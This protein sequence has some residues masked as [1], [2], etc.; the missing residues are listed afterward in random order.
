MNHRKRPRVG[1][2]RFYDAAR[3]V[4]GT[5]IVTIAVVGAVYPSGK[6]G[7]VVVLWCWWRLR[8]VVVPML[9]L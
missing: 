8:V 7:S 2:N 6:R 9:Q 1:E 4:Y 3:R 5:M